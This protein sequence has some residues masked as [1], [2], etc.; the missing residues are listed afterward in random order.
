MKAY[1]LG[2]HVPP[3][4]I[5]YFYYM[6]RKKTSSYYGHAGKA[7]PDHVRMLLSVPP[8]CSIAHTIGFYK[9]KNSVRTH[10]KILKTKGTLFG[11]NFWPRDDFRF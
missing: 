3:L 11:R 8:K 6:L 10:R 7:M 1:F 2:L 4:F 5:F 9:G